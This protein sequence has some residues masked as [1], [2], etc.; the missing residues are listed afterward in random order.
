MKHYSILLLLILISS[1]NMLS[2]QETETDYIEFN[3]RKNTV[4]GVYLGLSFH[5]GTIDK[6][7]TYASSFKVA[8]VANQQFEIGFIGTGFY[9]DLNRLG[10]DN[11]NRDLAGFYGGLH[12]EPIF[13]GKSKFNLSLPLLIGGGAV[14]LL[15][16]DVFND[17]TIEEDDWKGVFV[18]EPGVNVLYN[19]SRYIQLEAGIKYR[20]SSKLN[21]RPEY[22]IS[23]I[24]GFSA[25]IGVKL[26]VFNMGRN[27]YKQNL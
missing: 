6:A 20:F 2:G 7:D 8:Y 10:T 14:G 21:L 1:I 19:I 15:N 9:T 17:V 22:N 27:R 3:D 5:Y 26:G 16:E 11:L 13:F 4:H 12:L 18:A 24:N 23:N 25:G